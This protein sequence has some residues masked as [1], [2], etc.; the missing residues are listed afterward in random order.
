MAAAT[1]AFQGWERQFLVA[2]L[3]FRTGVDRSRRCWLGYDLTAHLVSRDACTRA[4]RRR[5]CVLLSTQDSVALTSRPIR[6][7]SALTLTCR[8]QEAGRRAAGCPHPPEAW[9]ASS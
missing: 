7:R 6:C 5:R 1:R 4:H 2:D 3:D 8:R 9:L